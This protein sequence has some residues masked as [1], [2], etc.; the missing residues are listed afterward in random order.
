MILFGLVFGR[1]WRSALLAA[2][3][4]WPAVLLAGDVT[5]PG[6]ALLGAA[7]LAVVNALVGVVVHQAALR[8]VRSM[9]RPPAG[10]RPGGTGTDYPVDRPPMAGG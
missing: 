2:G 10:R 3:V 7:G 8:I 9:R 1:W 5:R 6:W 4:V